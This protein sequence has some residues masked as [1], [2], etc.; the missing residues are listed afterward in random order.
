[1]EATEALAPWKKPLRHAMLCGVVWLIA[2]LAPPLAPLMAL[3]LPM[4]TYPMLTR[5]EDFEAILL[6]LMPS[7][8]F[9]LAGYDPVISLMLLLPSY[10]GFL[11]LRLSQ[12]RIVPF[13]TVTLLCIAAVLISALLMLMRLSVLLDGPL[14]SQLAQW[15]VTRLQGSFNS[16]ALLYRMVSVGYLDLPAA[17]GKTAGIQL[18]S[19]ILLNP[20]LHRELINMLRLR[21]YEDISSYLPML[22]MQ[23]SIV[24]GLFTSLRVYNTFLR[25]VKPDAPPQLLRTLDLPRRAR[26][27]LLVLAIGTAFTSF[28]ADPV[29]SLICL[30]M[31]AAFAAIFELLGAAVLVFILA[32]RKPGRAV[33]Y[34]ILA[35]LLYVLFPLALF[36]LGV[37][38][39]LMH[40]RAASLHHQEEESL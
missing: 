5:G 9:S 8:A 28:S 38:D 3:T 10:I 23:G 1:M 33:W 14:F 32:R 7:V 11:P 37:A 12:R 34:G 31:Y 21:L 25:K 24:I 19:V 17:Y 35:A 30:L 26:G 22:L 27:Y 6:P 4:L 13:S 18:G 36:L 15:F 20:L 39:Q 16:G 2:Y 29:V 40:L